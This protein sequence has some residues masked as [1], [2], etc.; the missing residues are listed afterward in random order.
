MEKAEQVAT[1]GRKRKISLEEPELFTSSFQLKNRRLSP[2]NSAS[3]SADSGNSI[4]ETV[5]PVHDLA[6]CSSSNGS[7]ELV[8]RNSK[9]ADLEENEAVV[10]FCPTSAGDTLDCIERRETAPFL[11]ELE[12]WTARPLESDSRKLLTAEKMPSEAEIE[13]FFEA[14][15]KN[16][17]R[18]FTE[19]YNYDIV[20]DKPLEG[21]Y[22]WAQVQLSPL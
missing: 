5:C 10:D 14:A 8:K 22:E 4:S 15:E 9:F 17:Q 11:E 13:E 12:T 21:R 2:E 16:I 18:K 6:S 1:A 19:K 7:S 3:P 20:K